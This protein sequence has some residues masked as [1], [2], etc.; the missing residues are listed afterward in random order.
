VRRGLVFRSA[1][2]GRVEATDPLV[3]SLG[4][5]A[6]YDLRTELERRVR[7]DRELPG[8]RRVE[9]DVLADAPDAVPAAVIE[10]ISDPANAHAG[11]GG[12]KAQRLFETAYREAVSLPSGLAAYRQLFREL[13]DPGNRPAL[14]HCTAGKDRAGWATAALLMLLGVP[15]DVVAK[16]YLL[17]NDALLPVMKPFF[18]DFA[19]KGGD[20][21][22]LLPVIGV[23]PGYLEAAIDE[24]HAHFGTV[25]AYFTDGL[26]LDERIIARLRHDLVDHD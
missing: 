3:A 1:D 2:L 11:L 24:M 20:P 22:L 26:G 6:V 14:V 17:T 15:D 23:E 16:E 19:A 25:D 5:C 13:A 12:G 18:E 9:L 8:A 10:I 4:I 21:D 7:P